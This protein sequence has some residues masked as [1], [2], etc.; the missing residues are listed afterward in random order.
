MKIMNKSGQS[1]F[2]PRFEP[3]TF[4]IELRSGTKCVNMLGDVYQ[5]LILHGVDTRRVSEYMM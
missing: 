5:K 3:A 1:V 2:R 4:R